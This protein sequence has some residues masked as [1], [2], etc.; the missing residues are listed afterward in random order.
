MFSI[1]NS[2]R[3]ET[4]RPSTF[5]KTLG[6]MKDHTSILRL[7]FSLSQIH[8]TKEVYEFKN[9]VNTSLFS[10][11]PLVGSFKFVAIYILFW[12]KLKFLFFLKKKLHNNPNQNSTKV[13]RVICDMKFKKY[14]TKKLNK[15]T[16]N[17]I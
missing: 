15:K 8:I 3:R 9:I 14:N 13:T 2:S 4:N 7:L 6:I 1:Q 10:G 16:I 11:S 5:F 12:Y 17:L